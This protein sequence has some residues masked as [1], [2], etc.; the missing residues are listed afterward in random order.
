MLGRLR[1]G[2]K[3]PKLRKVFHVYPDPPVRVGGAPALRCSE[4]LVGGHSLDVEELKG[5]AAHLD[6]AVERGRI[7]LRVRE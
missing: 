2:A 4:S 5:F 3:L 6:V 7:A 1:A